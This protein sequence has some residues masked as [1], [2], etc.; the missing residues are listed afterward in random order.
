MKLERAKIE[1][2]EDE[3]VDS[4]WEEN[5]SRVSPI[6]RTRLRAS[7]NKPEVASVIT[8]ETVSKVCFFCNA[9]DRRM[10]RALTFDLDNNKK[11]KLL[12]MKI[13][14]WTLLGELA[15]GDMDAIDVDYHLTCLSSLYN[16][17]RF[18]SESSFKDERENVNQ[19]AIAFAELTIYRGWSVWR[20]NCIFIIWSGEATHNPIGVA[21]GHEGP[22]KN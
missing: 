18:G 1:T 11:S 12:Y 7:Y 4:S 14:N 8:Q 9:T 22:R 17:A 6:K 5:V 2:V 3:S 19:E 13:K 10:H 15:S 16:S 20:N 21:I